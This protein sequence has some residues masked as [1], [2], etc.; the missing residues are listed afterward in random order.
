MQEEETAVK[1]TKRPM[2]GEETQAK[3]P[4]VA[5]EP[6][7]SINSDIDKDEELTKLKIAELELHEHW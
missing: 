4:R 2:E 5:D 7:N 3:R 1:K 6:K